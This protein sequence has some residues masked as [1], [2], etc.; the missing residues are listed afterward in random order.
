MYCENVNMEGNYDMNINKETHFTNSGFAF[1]FILEDIDL[2]RSTSLPAIL[3][4]LEEKI[5]IAKLLENSPKIEFLETQKH[6]NETIRG[7]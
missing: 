5:D 7:N 1:E 4:E 3:A 2:R 6:E